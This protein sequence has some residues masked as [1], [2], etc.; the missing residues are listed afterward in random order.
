MKKYESPE[1]EIVRFVNPD[2]LAPSDYTTQDDETTP[3]MRNI[4]S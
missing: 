3:V 1:M 4:F 2:V